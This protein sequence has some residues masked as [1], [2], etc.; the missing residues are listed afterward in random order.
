M[1]EDLLRVLKTTCRWPARRP[2]RGD[3]GFT[4]ESRPFSPHLTLARLRDRATPDERQRLGQIIAGIEMETAYRVNVDSIN[5]M[6]S[7]LT[8]D[9]AIYS[10]ISSI[11]LK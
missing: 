9:G 6:K 1:A 7:Q 5:L 8:R 3:S 2:R 4:P 10:R 11:K